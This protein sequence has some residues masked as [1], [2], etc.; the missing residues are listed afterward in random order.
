MLIKLPARALLIA[1]RRMRHPLASRQSARCHSWEPF[2]SG[3]E[4]K[5]NAKDQT[6]MK[7]H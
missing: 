3:K 2:P 1:Y 6:S 7:E 4:K 5:V